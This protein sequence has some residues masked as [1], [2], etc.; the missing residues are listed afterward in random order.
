M[1]KLRIERVGDPFADPLLVEHRGVHRAERT[2]L[3]GQLEV[4]APAVAELRNPGLEVDRA[5]RGVV[6]GR[7]YA[8]ALLPVVERYGGHVVE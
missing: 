7:L 3:E 1:E 4:V 6:L 2:T 5:G 8:R